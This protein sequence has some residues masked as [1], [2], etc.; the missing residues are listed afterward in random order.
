MT[1]A[2][3]SKEHDEYMLLWETVVSIEF[4]DVKTTKPSIYVLRQESDLAYWRYNDHKLDQIR[5]LLLSP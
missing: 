2:A 4:E 5:A 3:I 1:F